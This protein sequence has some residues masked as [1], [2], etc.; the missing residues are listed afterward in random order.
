MLYGPHD[1]DEK[2]FSNLCDRAPMAMIDGGLV[3]ILLILVMIACVPLA[4]L[5][6]YA[7]RNRALTL[8]FALIGSGALVLLLVLVW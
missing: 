1:P 6:K 4:M 8:L 2:T 3:V 5:S 7:W